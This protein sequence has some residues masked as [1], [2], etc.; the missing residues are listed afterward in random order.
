[1]TVEPISV[2][3]ADDQDLIRDALGALLSKHREIRV[4]GQARNGFE[5]VSETQRL[6]PNVVLM[7]VRMPGLTGYEATE[8][9][10]G[11]RGLRNSRVLIL[12][13][14]EDPDIV[15]ECL[16]C[17]AAGFIG[18]GVTS[19]AL[20][21]AIFAVHAGETPLSPRATRAV[22]DSIGRG[23][24]AGSTRDRRLERLT[25][26]ELEIVTLVGSGLSNAEIGQ[27][28]TISPDTA[29]THLRNIMKKL[30]VHDRAQL[31]SLAHRAGIVD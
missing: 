12:T 10:R 31:V 24:S 16:R 25:P 4:V 5:A 17:G 21:E 8:Q 11:I 15:R 7:D 22:V 20:V 30:E 27:R 26:R 6:K 18:K 19:A 3:V 28:L 9:I 14:F 1:M 2:L 23:A 29:K 13:T